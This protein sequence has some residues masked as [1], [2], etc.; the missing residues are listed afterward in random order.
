MRL[1]RG[2]RVIGLPR[3]VSALPMKRSRILLCGE[4]PRARGKFAVLGVNRKSW[5][6]CCERGI[7]AEA[8]E[9]ERVHGRARMYM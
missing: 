3:K 2:A 8:G 7:F 4:I 9:G 5:D 6:L 1:P